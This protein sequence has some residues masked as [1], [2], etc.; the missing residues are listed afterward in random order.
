MC[1]PEW[2]GF[3]DDCSQ[4]AC[5]SELADVDGENIEVYCNNRGACANTVNASIV[6]P[7]GT[8][9]SAEQHDQ[10]GRLGGARSGRRGLMRLHLKA[11]GCPPHS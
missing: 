10:S 4:L 6:C 3:S 8:V 9:E 5:P 1:E 7:D 11:W 2:S